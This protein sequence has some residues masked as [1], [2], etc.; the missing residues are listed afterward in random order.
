MTGLFQQK[1]AE[2]PLPGTKQALAAD[3]TVSQPVR[4]QVCSSQSQ[5]SEN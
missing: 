5:P 4:Q 1:S 3:H 2:V